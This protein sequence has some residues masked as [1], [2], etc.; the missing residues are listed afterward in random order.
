[1]FSKSCKYGIRAVLHLAVYSSDQ[2]KLGVTEIA[3]QLEVPK[4]FLAK[5]LQ[6]LTKANL[7]S[8]IKGPSGGYYLSRKNNESNLKEVIITLDGSHVFMGC[9]LGL[10][11][12]SS[13]KPCPLHFHA[14]GI[15]EG[16]NY[17]LEYQTIGEIAEKIIRT[18]LSI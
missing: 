5:I 13:E 8:S 7:I 14:F 1:M 6:Q 15:R 3:D 2:K 12:C 11:E 10:K 9:I 16:L 18:N 17:Q 4:H